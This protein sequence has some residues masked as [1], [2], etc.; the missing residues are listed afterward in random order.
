MRSELYD[1]VAFFMVA[2]T[3]KPKFNSLYE[4]RYDLTIEQIIQTKNVPKWVREAVVKIKLLE[5]QGISTKGKINVAVSIADKME[6]TSPIYEELLGNVWQWEAESTFLNKKPYSNSFAVEI[7]YGDLFWVRI[8]ENKAVQNL[9]TF[10]FDQEGFNNL[11]KNTKI[12]SGGVTRQQYR[13]LLAQKR[14]SVYPTEN[15]KP[16]VKDYGAFQIEKISGL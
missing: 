9:V 12:I 8:T 11:Y 2:K 4:K 7:V 15:F 13:E 14:Q 1:P 3:K 6:K 10:T 16:G 5:E